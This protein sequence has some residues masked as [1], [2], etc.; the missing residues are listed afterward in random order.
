[1]LSELS[2]EQRR[3]LDP[4]TRVVEAGPGSG[5][6]RALVQRY[7]ESTGSGSGGVVMLSFTNAAID[8]VRRRT[9]STPKILQAPHFVGTIDSFLHR[10]I[11]TPTEV[12]RLRRLP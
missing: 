3:V 6:T 11:V 8:E 10:F 4:G 2:D 1:M 12:A 5:K 9:R 7:I